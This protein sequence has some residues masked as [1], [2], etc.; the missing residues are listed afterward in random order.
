MSIRGTRRYRCESGVSHSVHLARSPRDKIMSGK[1]QKV[2]RNCSR[3]TI[4][5]SIV[6]CDAEKIV[7]FGVV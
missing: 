6:R 7:D 1:F 3:S 4:M 2:C 5:L